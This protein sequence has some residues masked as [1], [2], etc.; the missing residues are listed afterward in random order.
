MFVQ[1][2]HGE[3]ERSISNFGDD[4]SP[5][6]SLGDPNEKSWVLENKLSDINERYN[7]L[8]LLL[9]ERGTLLDKS[10]QQLKD[11]DLKANQTLPWLN[12]AEERLA[13][14]TAQPIG[15]D[16]AKIRREIDELKVI[17]K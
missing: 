17:V 6:E 12:S 10:W 2:F 15:N 13:R 1:I 3:L 4:Q 14:K 11:Y 8:L 9:T 16:T 5:K 7:R